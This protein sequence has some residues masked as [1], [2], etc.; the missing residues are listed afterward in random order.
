MNFKSLLG[1]ASIALFL[2]GCKQG[3]A[4]TTEFQQNHQTEK[5]KQ[6]E[7]ENTS[8][9]TFD[10]ISINSTFESN[11]DDPEEAKVLKDLLLDGWKVGIP[12]SSI[13]DKLPNNVKIDN[14][15]TQYAFQLDNL[16]LTFSYNGDLIYIFTDAPG[17]GL[18]TDIKVGDNESKVNKIL[19][20][21]DPSFT[22]KDGYLVYSHIVDAVELKIFVKDKVVHGISLEYTG[23]E[24]AT[25]DELISKYYDNYI[26]TSNAIKQIE[27]PKVA[28]QAEKKQTQQKSS[29]NKTTDIVKYA[30]HDELIALRNNFF[31]R[32]KTLLDVMINDSSNTT[33]ITAIF[34]DID[35]YQVELDLEKASSHWSDKD[36]ILGRLVIEYIRAVLDVLQWQIMK[37]NSED[38]QS[39]VN[40]SHQIIDATTRAHNSNQ[41]IL[42]ILNFKE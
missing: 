39:K 7:K 38:Y 28:H 32:Y 37:N 23:R 13:V 6:T 19:A 42:T 17:K 41:Q 4:P 12:F 33:K 35:V 3:V 40:A 15:F 10:N 26:A 22:S 30:T 18:N 21:S 11:Q 8:P 29:E 24:N 27:T 16:E 2:A 5:Q 1:A 25:D 36:K 9:L 31:N 20:V 34:S 14:S